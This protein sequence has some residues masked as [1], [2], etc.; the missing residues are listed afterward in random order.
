MLFGLYFSVTLENCDKTG[1]L[2]QGDRPL[3]P[4]TSQGDRSC[5]SESIIKKEKAACLAAKKGEMSRGD[6]SLGPIRKTGQQAC[7]IRPFVNGLPKLRSMLLNQINIPSMYG[8]ILN[9]LSYIC[10]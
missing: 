4:E 5:G 7:P 2:S 10:I 8:V 3:G 6:R 9:L 1:N